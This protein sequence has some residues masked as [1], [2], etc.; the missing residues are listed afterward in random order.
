MDNEVALEKMD[1]LLDVYKAEVGEA[2][3]V[4]SDARKEQEQTSD[5]EADYKYTKK[6]LKELITHSKQILE[7]AGDIAMETGEPRSIEVYSQLV[8]NI[9]DL[10]KSVM[11]NSRQK[12]ATEKDKAAIFSNKHTDSP[13][14]VTNN[15]T[16]FVGSTKELLRAI[17]EE[18]DKII[19]QE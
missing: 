6:Q 16:I 7:H 3:I 5:I 8:K 14:T 10:A 11:D 15:Q 17:K 1:A 18:Q 9:G 2:N 13:G 4:L 12:V 19:I